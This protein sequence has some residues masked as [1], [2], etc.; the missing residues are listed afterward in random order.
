MI[1]APPAKR[2]SSTLEQEQQELLTIPYPQPPPRMQQQ[3]RQHSKSKCFPETPH[4]DASFSLTDDDAFVASATAAAAPAN[5][6]A[7]HEV[8]HAGDSS[9]G[10]LDDCAGKADAPQGPRS[11]TDRMGNSDRTTTPKRKG[12]AVARRWRQKKVKRG[13]LEDVWLRSGQRLRI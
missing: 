11:V 4:Q 8:V 1:E 13:S 2:Q 12:G 9:S 6:G 10:K 5:G 3:H 7:D